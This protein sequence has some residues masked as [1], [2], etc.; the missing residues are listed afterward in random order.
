MPTSKCLSSLAFLLSAAYRELYIPREL[1]IEHSFGDGLFCHKSDWQIFPKVQIRALEDKIREWI[2]SGTNL[3]LDTIPASEALRIFEKSGLGNKPEIIRMTGLDSLPIVRYGSHWDLLIDPMELDLEKLKYFEIRPYN[4]GIILRYLSIADGRMPAFVD[5]P[6]LFYIFREHQRWSDII[7][8]NNIAQLNRKV[9]NN[10]NDLVW[11]AEG[12][13]EK[14]LSEIADRLAEQFYQ[15]RV[16]FIAGPSASGK[17]TFAR[18]L[19]IQ[20]QVNGFRTKQISMDDYFCDRDRIPYETDGSQNFEALSTVNADLLSERIDRLLNGEEVPVRHYNFESGTGSDL[21][22]TMSLGRREFLIIEGIHGLNPGLTYQIAPG[23]VQKIYISAITQLNIDSD[24][25]LSTTDNRLLRRIVRD[26]QFRG[27]STEDTL[28]RWDSVRMGEVKNI[29]PYQEES[30]FM[31]NSALIYE[32]SVL[33]QRAK[34]LLDIIQ[35]D[36][37]YYDEA[38]RLSTLLSYFEPLS[39]KLVPNISIL[40]EF[41]G[42][43]AL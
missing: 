20:L 12:L 8:V 13:Q 30:D 17:T 16:I 36:S 42:G 19:S 34:P 10:Q 32:F 15:R 33:A 24:H 21:V 23:S 26:Q 6:N 4:R 28:S 35:P 11:V 1:V 22:K 39:E 37:T 14:K 29:F 7:G 3:T 9:R 43:S 5:R 18:R 41:I 31:F 2:N 25:R 38:R 40:R 27:Y